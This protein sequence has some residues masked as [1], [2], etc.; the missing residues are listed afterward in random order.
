MA[1]RLNLKCFK[2]RAFLARGV[3]SS[4]RACQ[5]VSSPSVRRA[6]PLRACKE[7]RPRCEVRCFRKWSL[8]AP[9]LPRP[10]HRQSPSAKRNND[11]LQCDR[12]RAFHSATRLLDL[13]SVSRSRISPPGLLSCC[14]C[15]SGVR[16]SSLGPSLLQLRSAAIMDA[17]MYDD[18]A[19]PSQVSQDSQHGEQD[20][21][22]HGHF[23]TKKTFHKPTYCHHCT[24]MLWGLIGQGYVCE[25]EAPT[26]PLTPTATRRRLLHP[27]HPH[28]SPSERFAH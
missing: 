22:G 9:P 6:P 7:A 23:F 17:T 4:S 28:S 1:N 24:D 10:P 2:Q 8:I 26:P 21:F 15:G 16:S 14:C 27:R 20:D 25:G 19:S 3:V 18:D 5:A 13:C 11:R 12:L